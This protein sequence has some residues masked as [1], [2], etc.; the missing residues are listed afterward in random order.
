MVLAIIR[1]VAPEECLAL[2]LDPDRDI[3]TPMAPE[4][5]LFLVRETLVG[6]SDLGERGGE[7]GAQGCVCG[8]VRAVGLQVKAG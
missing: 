5:G 7:G 8:G 6:S 2:A 1:G 3:H 4:L